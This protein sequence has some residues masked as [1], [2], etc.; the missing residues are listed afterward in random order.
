MTHDT[1][2]WKGWIPV[3]PIRELVQ[4]YV[5]FYKYAAN[6]ED[7]QLGLSKGPLHHLAEKIGTSYDTLQKIQAG[8]TRCIKFDM[9]DKLLCAMSIPHLWRDDPE[10][11]ELYESVELDEG[12]DAAWAIGEFLTI[13]G[14]WES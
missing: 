6:D 7:R 3:A 14:S 4:Q 2:C 9:A 8:R 10:L 12:M 11:R 1:E 5:D 13:G